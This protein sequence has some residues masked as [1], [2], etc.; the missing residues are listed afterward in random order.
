YDVEDPVATITLH[1]PEVL[2]AWTDR[3]GAEV[4]H[5]VA[6]AEA[7][8]RVVGI[9]LTG[10][11][12]GFC[13]GADM[14]RLAAIG[15]EHEP[16]IGADNGR[17]PTPTP[18][19]LA[20]LD[21]EPGDP[22]FGDDLHLGTYTYLMSVPKPVIAAINGPVAGMGVPIVLAC[23]LRFMAEDAVL[24]TSFSQRGL[25][26][27]YGISWLLP[28][29]V[30]TAVALDLLFSSRKVT[31]VEAAAMRVVNAAL[32]R[33]DVLPHAQQYV[34]DLAASAS[35]ASMAIMKRQVYQQLHAGLLA[36]EQEARQLMVESF[37][38][39]DFPEGVQSYL[40]RRQPS[41]ERLPRSAGTG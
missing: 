23:D 13:A 30:G 24:T 4:R 14:S 35:P 26:A 40:E 37:G 10:A 9:V 18:E 34:R 27:E 16:A 36:A 15:G 38:R 32:P 31:G 3:M 20:S 8:P 41:F 33:A 5:A 22:A 29:L 39:P 25:I 21:A 6:A 1:R 17:Q 7:D 2:N 12:R 19:R 11:G 28:R